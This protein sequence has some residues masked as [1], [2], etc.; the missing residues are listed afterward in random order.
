[1]R[2]SI[3]ARSYAEAL[4]ELGERQHAHD[5]F[6][7][8]LNTITTLLESDPRVRAFLE[9][10]KLDVEQKKQA[11]RK[12]LQSQVSPVFLNFV[13]VVLRKRRQRLLHA[14]AAAY[15]DLLDEKLGRLHVHVT[16]AHE[17]DEQT[18]QTVIAELSR[19]LGRTVIPHVVVD[20][21]LLG[22]IVVRYGDNVMDGSLRRQL[23]SLR[24]RMVE[25]A[26]PVG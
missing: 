19:I 3:V 1:M 12:A 23:L 11:L 2:G 4:F 25:A 9:T 18:E 22:G 20:P 8:G 5:D 26:L 24:Q 15:R 17:P 10:P 7:H 16:M 13:L 6:T 21:A 14:I